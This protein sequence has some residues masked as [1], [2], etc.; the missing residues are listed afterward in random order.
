MQEKN[1]SHILER[2][3]FLFLCVLSNLINSNG[4]CLVRCSFNQHSWRYSLEVVLVVGKAFL[5]FKEFANYV[6][7]QNSIT[8][9]M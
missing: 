2:F 1:V 8:F 5:Y 7:T 9:G 3:L 6:L 4:S